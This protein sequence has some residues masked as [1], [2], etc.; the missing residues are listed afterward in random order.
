M[1]L[2][3]ASKDYAQIAINSMSK[4]QKHPHLES[5]DSFYRIFSDT[6]GE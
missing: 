6:K 1:F 5:L 2:N 4:G 3:Y